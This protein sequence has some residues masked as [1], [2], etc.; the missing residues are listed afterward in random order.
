MSLKCPFKEGDRIRCVDPNLSYSE[1]KG[2]MATVVKDSYGELC[3]I[4]DSDPKRHRVFFWHRFELAEDTVFHTSLYSYIK[5]E[6]HG[7]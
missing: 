5:R 7:G 2:Q 6:L 3:Q 1:L 4:F